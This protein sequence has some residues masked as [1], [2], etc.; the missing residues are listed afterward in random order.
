L[1]IEYLFLLLYNAATGVEYT[2]L[3]GLFSGLLALLQGIGVLF[4]LLFLAL[5]VYLHLRHEHIH[6]E[7]EHSQ[8]H[9]H[10]HIGEDDLHGATDEPPAQAVGH[11]R[12]QHVMT[13]MTE[14]HES[15]WR[16]A[17]VE[18]DILLSEL[19]NDLRLPGQSIGDQLKQVN[20]SQ[21]TTLDLAW[22]AHKTRND[23]AH[24]GST[25]ALTE[26]EARRTI[27]LYRQ[28]F[29]EFQYI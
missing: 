1:N 8:S 5:L 21:F 14:P 27:D 17:I 11:A 12:W 9:G 15:A 25:F 23:I 19:L 28:V 7:Y 4:S 13:L 16:Q 26:R 20:R 24:R 18:A 3:P 6:H 10:G 22:E 29:D 2:Q